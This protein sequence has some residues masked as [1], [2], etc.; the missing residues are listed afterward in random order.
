MNIPKKQIIDMINNFPGN[1][2][3]EEFIYRLYLKEKLIA[4][5]ENV[6]NGETISHE[7]FIKETESWIKK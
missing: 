7:D 4:A 5:E 2:D 3:I 1:V 6:N